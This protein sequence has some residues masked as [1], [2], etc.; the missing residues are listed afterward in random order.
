MPIS[1]KVTPR[2]FHKTIEIPPSKSYAGRLIIL[3]AMDRRKIVLKNVPDCL[4]ISCLLG[5]LEKIGLKVT[6]NKKRMVVLNSFPACERSRNPISLNIGDGA[7]PARFLMTL[8]SR[9]K[10]TYRLQI[11]ESLNARPMDELL[12]SLRCLQVKVKKDA[13]GYFIQGPADFPGK[14]VEIDCEKTSQ[15]ASAF[16]LVFAKDISLKIKNLNSSKKYLSLSNNLLENFKKKTA[17][18]IPADFSSASY[19]LALGLVSGYTRIPNIK[20]RDEYQADTSI[21]DVIKKMGGRIEF[22]DVGLYVQKEKLKKIELDCSQ[23]LDLVPAIAFLCSQAEGKSILGGLKNLK[24]KESDRLEEIRRL[25]VLA[26]CEVDKG[27]DFL[28]IGGK[29]K[30]RFFSYHAP[31]D[32]RMIMAAY[33]FMRSGM[34]GVIY[35]AQ[36]VAKSWPDFFA[37]MEN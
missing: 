10:K 24:Y 36:S 5:A 28:V 23:F 13:D 6:G 12:N 16:S 33:L 2:V 29:T 1:F 9:G 19:P 7:M 26:G 34:G 15:Y 21:I 4:D 32:H 27:A 37:Q 22:D 18:E 17:F 20:N 25:L 31:N 14:T 35:N 30:S 3:A 8:L 11:S